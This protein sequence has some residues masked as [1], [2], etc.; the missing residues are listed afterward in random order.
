MLPGSVLEVAVDHTF[1]E[2]GQSGAAGRDPTQETTDQVE[3]PPSTVASEAELNETRVVVLDELPM[4]SVLEALEQPAP[5]QVLFCNHRL[6]S[7]VE[8]GSTER[9]MPIR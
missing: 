1:I 7:A 2:V 8:S 4:G 6:S 3:A 5:A 9:N